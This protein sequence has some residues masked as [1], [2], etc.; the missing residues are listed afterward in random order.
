MSEDISVF[1]A[2]GAM[3]M[4]TLLCR[5]GGY[6]IFSRITPPPMMRRALT[7]LPG[8]IFAA[9][10]VPALVDGPAQNWAGAAA[11]MAVMAKSRNLGISIAAG[12]VAVFIYN[13]F[14]RQ[15]F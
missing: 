10:V 9:Y 2:I 4:V 6:L 15:L 5:C 8:C 3:A 13:Y 14:L 1:E 12:I 11:T 7:H